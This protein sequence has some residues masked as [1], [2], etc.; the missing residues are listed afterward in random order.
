MPIGVLRYYRYKQCRKLLL[1]L[2]TLHWCLLNRLIHLIFIPQS[3][4]NQMRSIIGNTNSF[5]FIK[6]KLIEFFKRKFITLCHCNFR[7][8]FKSA[9]S[10]PHYSNL[11][12]LVI[13][14]NIF[15]PMWLC[16]FYS[17][18]V[19]GSSQAFSSTHKHKGGHF[20]THISIVSVWVLT[21]DSQT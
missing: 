9:S 18:L 4:S 11:I 1:E 3:R 5:T 15:D 12:F 10:V 14:L 8:K 16:E 21:S 17:S 13:G 20:T 19:C 6:A 7:L 2:Q